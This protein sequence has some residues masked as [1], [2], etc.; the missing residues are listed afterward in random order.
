ML[1][2][3]TPFRVSLFGG[4]TDVP[5]YFEKEGGQVLGFAIN[6]YGYVTIRDLP[7]FYDHKIRLSYSK[8]EQ[9]KTIKE[10]EHPLIRA[11]LHDFNCKNIEIHYD[12]DLPGCSGIG[13]S[14]SFAVGLARGLYSKNGIFP[15]C[16]DLAKKAIYWE[17]DYLKEKG[18]YQD[19]IFAAYGGINHIKFNQDGGYSVNR[20][21]ITEKMKYFLETQTLLCYLPTKRFSHKHSVENFLEMN[22]TIHSLRSIKKTV[23]KSIELFQSENT[24]GLGEL[25]HEAWLYKRKLPNV[26]NNF[27]DEIYEK[28]LQNG[29]LGGK[30][31]GAGAGGFM[32]FLCKSNKRDN[33]I[34]A[35][36]PLIT[37]PLKI[38]KEGS[39]LLYYNA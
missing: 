36:S 4:G 29:A 9:C 14:S 15:T 17:R 20:F 18:G 12:A 34:K 28:A 31:L 35:L 37:F 19:Q 38:E 13:S 39:R 1:I 21:P 2:V 30:I 6:K 16:E 7:P 23:D 8:I 26:S 10:I 11:A 25:M 32:L 3:S 22:S 24:D 33:L 5:S 27:I